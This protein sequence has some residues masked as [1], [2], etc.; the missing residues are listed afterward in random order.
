MSVFFIPARDGELLHP[1]VR[2]SGELQMVADRI[3]WE[4]I[5]YYKQRDMQSLTTYDSFFR[6]EFGRDPRQEVKVRLL[7]YDE[8]NP[9]ESEPE[10]KEA[11]RRT[12]A[13]I[14]SWVLRNYETEQG[15]SSIRQGNR[16]ITYAGSVPTWRE[17]P[18]GWSSK[19]HNFDAKIAGYGI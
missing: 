14:V 16:S 9:D 12:V 17:W 15:A 3:E 11:L 10:L 19:L 5:D 6:F 13:D 4:I 1:D 2:G 8:E 18:V 7:G